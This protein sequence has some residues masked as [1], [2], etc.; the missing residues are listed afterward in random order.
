M[1][2]ASDLWLT[3]CK[4]NFQ[5]GAAGLV[6]GWMTVWAG[7]PSRYVTNYLVQ[8]SLP[9]IQDRKIDYRP[10]CL[11]LNWSVFTYVRW[12]VTLWDHTWHVTPRS[13]RV[14]LTALLLLIAKSILG[15]GLTWRG[16][17]QKQS[18]V[19]TKTKCVYG[20]IVLCIICTLILIKFICILCYCFTEHFLSIYI[21]FHSLLCTSF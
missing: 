6:L 15:S 7:K 14:S 11:G 17:I 1:V 3:G 20:I 13:C 5:P 21:N 18:V 10:I 9:S 16:L 4:F 12:Q 8:L 19:W 2:M